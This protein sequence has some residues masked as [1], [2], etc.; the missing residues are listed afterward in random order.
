[1]RGRCPGGGTRPL[2]PLSLEPMVPHVSTL[3]TPDGERPVGRGQGGPSQPPPASPP[4]PPG[5]GSGSGPGG[6]PPDEEMR[7]QLDEMRQQILPT[8][9]AVVVAN[10]AYGIF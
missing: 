3:W 4:P 2:F 9:A 8:P 5:S 6:P 10:H 7:A 1:M